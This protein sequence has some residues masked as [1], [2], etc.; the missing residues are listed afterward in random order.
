ME[1][2]KIC[3]KCEIKLPYFTKDG[4]HNFVPS[5]NQNGKIIDICMKCKMEEI[6][7][8]WEG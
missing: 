6:I 3:P 8:K 5:V 2:E 4:K 7:K 1:Y